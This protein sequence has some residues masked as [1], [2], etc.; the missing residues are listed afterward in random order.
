MAPCS[1]DIVFIDI[2]IERLNDNVFSDDEEEIYALEVF[3]A[4]LIL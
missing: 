2:N 1:N 3:C 4:N